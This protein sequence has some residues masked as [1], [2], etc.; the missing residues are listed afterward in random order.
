[1]HPFENLTTSYPLPRV[2]IP[3]I[4]EQGTAV[5][6][7]EAI[8]FL[9]RAWRYRLK[10]EAEEIRHIRRSV[11]SGDTVIDVGAHKGAFTYWLSRAVGPQGRVLAFEPQPEVAD[12]LRRA[13]RYFRLDNVE[14]LETALSNQ[15]GTATLFR[16]TNAV[17]PGA[18][19]EV[20][21]ATAGDSMAVTLRTLDEI[22]CE[23]NIQSV[24]L[25]KCDAEGHEL[26]VFQGA[27]KS[28]EQ[29]RPI[30][31]FEC[32]TR[33]HWGRSIQV[34]FDFLY[35]YGYRG[36]FFSEGEVLPFPEDGK[37]DVSR[38]PNVF[39]YWFD[40]ARRHKPVPVEAA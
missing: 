3:S 21:P 18:S 33:H 19:L 5:K 6:R 27:Q 34:V 23:K 7:L 13:I 32:E 40:D 30:L 26:K 20:D 25:I 15:N 2:K 8:R 24:R 12:Y 9:L 29:F 38:H 17:S 36:S 11:S 28:L 16:A 37:M 22:L 1:M 14:I 31:I 10:V 4:R 39:N 35:R